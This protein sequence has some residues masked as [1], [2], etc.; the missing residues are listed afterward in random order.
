MLRITHMHGELGGSLEMRLSFLTLVVYSY[1]FQCHLSLKTTSKLL[2]CTPGIT[3]A[4]YQRICKRSITSVYEDFDFKREDFKLA[5]YI[6]IRK[7]I[8]RITC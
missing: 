8:S 2:A 7:D 3:C 4:L 5:V 1:L 6:S